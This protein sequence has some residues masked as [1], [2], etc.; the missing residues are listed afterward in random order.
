MAALDFNYKYFE[1]AQNKLLNVEGKPS[2][3]LELILVIPAYKEPDIIRSI[4]SL[5]PSSLSEDQFEIFI[6]LNHSEDASQIDQIMTESSFL[7]I[8]EWKKTLENSGCNIQVF[9]QSLPQKFAGVGLARKIGMDAAARRFSE[10]K[11]PSGIIMTYDADCSC[12]KDHIAKVYT[13]FTKNPFVN[14]ASIHYEHRYEELEDIY[15]RQNIINY[16]LHLRAYIQWKKYIGL[17]YAFQTIGS[18]MAVRS[19]TYTRKGGMNKRKAGEDF[20]FLHKFTHDGTFGEI[21]TTTV[22]PSCRVSDR[23]PFGTGRAMQEARDEERKMLTY[24]PESYLLMGQFILDLDILYTK[25][26]WKLLN[27][28]ARLIEYLE[29]INAD[30]A[31]ESCFQNSASLASFKKRFFQWMNAFQMMKYLHYMRDHHFPNIAPLEVANQLFELN[32]ITRFK[33]PEVALIKMRSLKKGD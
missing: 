19:G 33:S 1:L 30:Q 3:N 11:N 24:H 17:P 29:S 15:S 32:E 9:K 18:S 6:I 16:E 31:I 26:R 22:F 7:K 14:A 4:T 23:V 2:Q 25:K 27:L 5:L 28:D 8:E 13:Y 10:I 21:N 12:T 20:Y